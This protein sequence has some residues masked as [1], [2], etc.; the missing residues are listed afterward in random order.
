MVR[1][2]HFA[3][4]PQI[5]HLYLL[6]GILTSLEL[7]HTR[8]HLETHTPKCGS[9][10]RCLDACPTQALIAPYQLNA[11]R[12]LS[13]HL[14]ESKSPIPLEI[15][16]KNPGYVFGCDICQ[17]VCPHNTRKA[18]S[19]TQEFAPERGIGVYLEIEKMKGIEEKPDKLFG[20]PLQ[21][22]GAK[23]LGENLRTL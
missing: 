22:K 5:W 15:Q 8:E 16:E 11:Q 18:P 17:D 13:Y 14:I 23:G 9:C 3:H 2:K 10:T 21:R 19:E 12:C 7:P 6:S 4:P 20:T 1:Q